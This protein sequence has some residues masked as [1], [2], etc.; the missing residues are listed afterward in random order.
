MTDKPKVTAL[1]KNAATA[2]MIYFDGAPTLGLSNSVVEIDL[3]A[4][5]M[6]LYP[7]NR[8]MTDNVCVAHLKCSIEA[9]VT[10]REA[11]NKALAMAHYEDRPAS[12]QTD[13]ED[14]PS[15]GAALARRIGSMQ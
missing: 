1:M 3:S 15:P 2:P 8:V 7:E 11:I 6:N 13:D 10:L 5:V 9:A 12:G 4:R 14:V